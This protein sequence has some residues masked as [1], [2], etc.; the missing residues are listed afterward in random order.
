MTLNDDA[1]RKKIERILSLF[2]LGDSSRNASEA[3]TFAAVSKAQEL[4]A[5]Y[6]GGG[7]KGAGACQIPRTEADATLKEVLSAVKRRG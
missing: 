7:H 6:G 4:M 2:R 1:K 5:K 3:E